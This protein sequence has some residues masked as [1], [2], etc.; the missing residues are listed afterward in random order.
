M[1]DKSLEILSLQLLGH[2]TVFD[3]QLDK[4]SV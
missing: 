3:G 4:D 1:L 2:K